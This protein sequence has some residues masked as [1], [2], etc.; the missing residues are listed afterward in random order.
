MG[1]AKRAHRNIPKEAGKTDRSTAGNR[2]EEEEECL[3][4]EPTQTQASFL[5]LLF[6][7]QPLGAFFSDI[8]S[9]PKLGQLLWLLHG[10]FSQNSPAFYLLEAQYHKPNSGG[11][12]LTHASR[13]GQQMTEH[14]RAHRPMSLS[15]RP[16]AWLNTDIQL[17]NLLPDVLKNSVYCSSL[18]FCKVNKCQIQYNFMPGGGGSRCC[19]LGKVAPSRFCKSVLFSHVT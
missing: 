10:M 11:I 4:T 17:P 5:N 1:A 19:H 8:S 18:A 16:H 7:P 2:C 3:S 14:N 13:T 6:T 12:L 9:P 15:D